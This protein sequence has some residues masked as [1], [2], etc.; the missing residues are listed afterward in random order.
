ME[1]EEKEVI[2]KLYKDYKDQH[3]RLIDVGEVTIA[4]AYQS[5]FSK[6]LLLA[7]A[8]Y[9]E[10]ATIIVIHNMLNPS[11]CS[12]TKLFIDNK[13]L[14]RQFH[15]LFEWERRDAGVNRFFSLFGADFKDFMKEKVKQDDL[16]KQSM[17][18]FIELGDQRNKL[19]HENYASFRL[20]LTTEEIY[21]KFKNAHIFIDKLGEYTNEFR[22]T[23][24]M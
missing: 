16:L 15:S 12:I 8:S 11:Q 5:Q 1:I 21:R 9:F 13:A 23:Y 4:N 17:G 20:N 10:S 24:E 14:K 3:A 22:L 19:V 2:D 6:V 7:S 18:D